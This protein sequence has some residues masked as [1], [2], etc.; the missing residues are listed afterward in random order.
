MDL[1][2]EGKDSGNPLHG[3]LFE[4]VAILGVKAV[5]VKRLC[6]RFKTERMEGGST[7][8]NATWLLAAI[9]V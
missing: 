5:R 8:V 4:K 6:Y 9:K 2:L 3:T 1:R 7:P